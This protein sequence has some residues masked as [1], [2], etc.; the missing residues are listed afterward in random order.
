MSVVIP[1]YDDADALVACLE[2]LGLQT[3]P[4]HC[5]EIL[6]VD[7]CSRQDLA[8][9]FGSRPGVTLISCATPGSYAARNQGVA[10]ALGPILAFTDADC[11][12]PPDWL[13]SGVAAL[14]REPEIAILGGAVEIIRR[15]GIA[16]AAELHQRLWAFPQEDWLARSRF[17]V[18]ANLFTYRSVFT[19]VGPFDERLFSSGDVEWCQRAHTKGHRMILCR[20][21]VTSILR[22][23]RCIRLY[24]G[25]CG[26]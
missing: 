13:E 16:S 7:N 21:V 14:R 17:L 10:A 23:R 3:Y 8:S 5:F 6:V 25:R 11:Q 26:W 4:A 18:T 24:G 22:V 15:Q 20:E 2:G 1:V 9:S 12:P 19:N